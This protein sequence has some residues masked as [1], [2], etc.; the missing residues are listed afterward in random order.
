MLKRR[1]YLM[2][3]LGNQQLNNLLKSLNDHDFS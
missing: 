1:K 2:C 3:G